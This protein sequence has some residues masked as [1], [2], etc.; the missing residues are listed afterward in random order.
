MNNIHEKK[1]SKIFF[2]S[3]I[4]FLCLPVFLSIDAMEEE[5][6]DLE[7]LPPE[8]ISMVLSYIHYNDSAFIY[9]QK[10][11]PSD[12]AAETQRKFLQSLM[13]KLKNSDDPVHVI[14]TLEPILEHPKHQKAKSV[15]SPLFADVYALHA[16]VPDAPKDRSQCCSSVLP[17]TDGLDEDTIKQTLNNFQTNT[18]SQWQQLNQKNNQTISFSDFMDSRE[19]V[20]E[21]FKKRLDAYHDNH[22][23]LKQNLPAAS[24][25]SSGLL[26]S[27]AGYC[28]A[29][30]P[31]TILGAACMVGGTAWIIANSP[32]DIEEECEHHDKTKIKNLVQHIKNVNTNLM[33]LHKKKQD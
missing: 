2:Y 9:L 3:L 12:T 33:L 10:C 8:L 21:H 1:C 14:S 28:M 5:K 11:Y 24:L 22:N 19:K 32:I 20:L 7:G 26:T 13:R 23:A 25:F 17:T 18:I 15:V 29:F 30:N 27:A 6:F 31:L 4:L 16:S